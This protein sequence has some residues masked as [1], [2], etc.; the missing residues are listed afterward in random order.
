M[1]VKV[2]YIFLSKARRLCGVTFI[3]IKCLYN[4]AKCDLHLV[5]THK[6]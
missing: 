2:F 4:Y 6:L 1:K 3:I 5:E